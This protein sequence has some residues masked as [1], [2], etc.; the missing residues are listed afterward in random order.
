MLGWWLVPVDTQSPETRGYTAC[1]VH[2]GS[3]SEA[4]YH[5][6]FTKLVA[7]GCSTLPQGGCGP[8]ALIP[9]RSSGAAGGGK[10]ALQPPLSFECIYP[11]I[12]LSS[13][14]RAPW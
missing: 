8:A 9:L 12:Q 7:R 1:I 6:H 10:P 4:L 14:A 2:K 3:H 5:M 11:S 13:A